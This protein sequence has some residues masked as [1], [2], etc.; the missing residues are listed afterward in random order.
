MRLL[1]RITQLLGTLLFAILL[2]AC[3]VLGVAPVIPKRKE[4]FGIE[5]KMD[6][7]PGAI[8]ENN[9]CYELKR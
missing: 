7:E 6:A 2:S 9:S 8:P 5:V 1:K 3:L 4:S